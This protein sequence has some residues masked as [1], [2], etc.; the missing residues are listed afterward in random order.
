MLSRRAYLLVWTLAIGVPVALAF[1]AFVPDL[2]PNMG[3]FLYWPATWYR[4]FALLVGAIA[5]SLA[6][7]YAFGRARWAGRH[8]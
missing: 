5:V 7:G 8:R 3:Q 1:W 6:I 2:E 4:R